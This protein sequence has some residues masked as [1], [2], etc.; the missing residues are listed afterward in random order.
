[1]ATMRRDRMTQAGEQNTCVSADSCRLASYLR[2]GSQ[3]CTG[4]GE[5]TGLQNPVRAALHA[6]DPVEQIVE[7][8]AADLPQDLQHHVLHLQRQGEPALGLEF[9]KHKALI[10]ACGIPES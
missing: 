6:L 8:A 7:R 4:V 5:N 9:V 1:M 3:R 10:G 2:D